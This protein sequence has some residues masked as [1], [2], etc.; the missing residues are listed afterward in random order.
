MVKFIK[1]KFVEKYWDD[2]LMWDNINYGFNFE[3]G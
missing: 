2:E 1:D 3:V